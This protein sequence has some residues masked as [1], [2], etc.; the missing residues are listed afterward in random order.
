MIATT[1]SHHELNTP[2]SSEAINEVLALIR[3]EPG[4]ACTWQV[5]E[6]QF[7]IHPKWYQFWK[8]P[9]Q[10]SSYSVFC[11]IGGFM[12]WQMINFYR[13]TESSI[14]TYVSEELVVNYLYGVL[15]GIHTHKYSAK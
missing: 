14:N 10:K 8:K 5:L 11:H 13:N 2:V 6:E 1:L 4:W 12:P 7:L 9:Q 15:A 3:K